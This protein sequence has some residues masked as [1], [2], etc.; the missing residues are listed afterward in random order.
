MLKLERPYSFN[1]AC[2][3]ARQFSRAL[4]CQA[5][6]TQRN[7]ALVRRRVG[8]TPSVFVGGLGKPHALALT[9]TAAFLVVTGHLQS[10]LEQQLLHRLQHDA[11]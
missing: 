2:T 6:T 11:G 4:D 3:A 7:D 8:D 5:G 10:Q 1:L 9:F